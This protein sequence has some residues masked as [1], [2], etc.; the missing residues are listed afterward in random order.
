MSAITN[1]RKLIT[2][3]KVMSFK[4]MMMMMMMMMKMKKK[5]K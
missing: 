1:L 3:V 2:F 5:K 4:M